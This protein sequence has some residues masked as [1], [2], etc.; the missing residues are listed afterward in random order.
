MFLFITIQ[1][2][3][4]RRSPLTKDQISGQIAHLESQALL[5]ETVHSHPTDSD[6]ARS[7]LKDVRQS[8]RL[9]QQDLASE[10]QKLEWL[11]LRCQQRQ[12]NLRVFG[13][14]YKPADDVCSSFVAQKDNVDKSLREYQIAFATAE[15]AEQEFGDQVLKVGVSEQLATIK[16]HI[17][18]LRNELE[19]APL[20]FSGVLSMANNSYDITEEEKRDAWTSFEFD[21]TES[22]NILHTESDTYQALF[23]W[24][25]D[26]GYWNEKGQVVSRSGSVLTSGVADSHVVMKAKTLKVRVNR[27]WFKAGIFQNTALTTVH[28]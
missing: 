26:A 13:A 27:P 19:K 21:S 11:R 18:E 4:C 5:L 14:S 9:A 3:L 23:Q 15:L 22:S 16:E 7:Y 25:I 6:Q 17:R 8:L 28:I 2:S 12:H 24:G 10:T 1:Y 20:S